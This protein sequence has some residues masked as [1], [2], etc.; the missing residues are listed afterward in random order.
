MCDLA[1]RLGAV[2][3]AVRLATQE[4][5]RP[6]T[7]RFPEDQRERFRNELLPFANALRELG[8][9][10]SLCSMNRLLELVDNPPVRIDEFERLG[11]ELHRR[12]IDELSACLLWRLSS[13]NARY[14]APDLMGPEVVQRFPSARDDVEE[15][16]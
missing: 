7:G 12:V 1:S 10:L 2:S 16:G 8:L 3:G 5:K 6:F 15:A 11:A 13:E 14:L 9:T 4:G